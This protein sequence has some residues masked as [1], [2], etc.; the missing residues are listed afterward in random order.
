MGRIPVYDQQFGGSPDG[1]SGICYAVAAAQ[2]LG[3]WALTRGGAPDAELPS[4]LMLDAA[5]RSRMAGKGLAAD[6]GE[7]TEDVL[8]AMAA[9]DACTLGVRAGARENLSID[10]ELAAAG[11]AGRAAFK[12]LAE[13]DGSARAS[14]RHLALPRF[15]PRYM[16]TRRELLSDGTTRGVPITADEFRSF[17]AKNS[18][19]QP[20]AVKFSY[21]TVLGEPPAEDGSD[22]GAPH[23]ALI[24][25]RA[26][27]ASGCQYLVRDSMGPGRPAVWVDESRLIRNTR[28][29]AVLAP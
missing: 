18:A 8:A 13:P 28:S 10:D 25:A 21:N 6:G 17:L 1:D 22:P 4:P 7:L 14:C 23:W 2:M 3:H 12:R 24:L 11:L 5:Q 15:T 26:G 29:M 20:V 19:R 27:R 9:R 16:R